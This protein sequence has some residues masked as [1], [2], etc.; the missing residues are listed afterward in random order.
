MAVSAPRDGTAPLPTH[1]VYLAT[2]D[3]TGAITETI[4]DASAADVKHTFSGWPVPD[5]VVP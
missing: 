3:E 2:M 4:D 1:V 5:G